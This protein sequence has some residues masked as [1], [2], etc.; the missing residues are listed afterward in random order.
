MPYG[1]LIL[2]DFVVLNFFLIKFTLSK[3]CIQLKSIGC[4]QAA[5]LECT[6]I[7]PMQGIK[8]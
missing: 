4:E 2:S 3:D 6:V 1:V 8:S 5:E 7:I